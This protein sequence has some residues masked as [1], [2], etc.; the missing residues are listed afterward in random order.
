MKRVRSSAILDMCRPHHNL[1]EEK[2]NDLPG[3]D[4]MIKIE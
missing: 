2:V 4:Q 1:T 3:P